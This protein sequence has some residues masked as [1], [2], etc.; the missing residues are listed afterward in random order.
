MLNWR[1]PHNP[2]AGGAERVSLAYMQGLVERGHEVVWFAN[3]FPGGAH[4][5]LINDIQVVR[6]GGKL[7][8]WRAAQ[9]WYAT[10]E[11]FDLVVDQHHGIPWYAPWWCEANCV[12]YIHEVLGPIWS[13]FYPWPLSAIGKWQERLTHRKYRE[14]PF[15]TTSTF[16]HDQLKAS[17]VGSVTTIPYGVET[18]VLEELPKKEL[19]EPLALI[20]VSRLAPN[21]QVDHA[22]KAVQCLVKE[23][24]LKVHLKIVGTGEEEAALKECMYELGVSD[25]VEFC[26]SLTEEKKDVALREAH[27]LLHTSIR[28]GWGLNV[29]EANAMGTPAV[30]YPVPGL[31][32]ST[33]HRQTGLVTDENTPSSLAEA[34]A[35]VQT[36]EGH[37]QDWRIAA[38]DRAR[39]FHWEQVLPV[40]CGQLEEWA[41][42]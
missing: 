20:V 19:D 33:L 29:I 3:K 11:P 30:V 14:V 15:W 26:G 5:E 37:Y 42:E 16:T 36:S 23:H 12:A 31:M 27:F 25:Y 22:I 21:K 7:T 6:D 41:K 32:E 13:A 38:R 40:A 35:N 17:G 4:E 24:E 18:R 2:L 8:S 39:E 9:K 34:I 28:E 1:D 10:Q